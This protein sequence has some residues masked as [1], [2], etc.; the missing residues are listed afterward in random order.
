MRSPRTTRGTCL[1]VARVILVALVACEPRSIDAI[2][3][4]DAE[5]R[6]ASRDATTDADAP[7]DG[8]SDAGGDVWYR[9]PFDDGIGFF[10]PTDLQTPEGHRDGR[11][12]EFGGVFDEWHTPDLGDG[13]RSLTL[14]KTAN[15]ATVRWRLALPNDTGRAIEGVRLRYDVETAWVRFQSADESAPEYDTNAHHVAWYDGETLLARS[16]D[17]VNV[18]VGEADRAR[19][20]TDEDQDRLGLRIVGVVHELP[21]VRVAPGETWIVEWGFDPS[22][23][24]AE[25]HMSVGIDELVV[26]AM[27]E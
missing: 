8:A 12:G 22:E 9:E 17:V 24:R 19:W 13:D 5:T 25:R 11:A 3:A 14:Y 21:D 10:T 26:E 4:R 27:N 2:I 16:G 1:F 23:S 18:A 20:L 6:D 7:T 15:L